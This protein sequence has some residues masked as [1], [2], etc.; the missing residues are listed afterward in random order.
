L[1]AG[2]IAS[3]AGRLAE[4]MTQA[5]DTLRKL[6]SS[7]SESIRLRAADRLL[8]IGVKVVELQELQSRVEELERRLA[9]RNP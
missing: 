5:A 9:E 1:R 7:E 8:E 4:G 6:L 3:A 2:F